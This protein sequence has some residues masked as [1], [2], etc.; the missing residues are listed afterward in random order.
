MQTPIESTAR[1]SAMPDDETLATTIA[2]LA[3]RGF[4]TEV[5]EDLTRRADGA[6]GLGV[7]ASSG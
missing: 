2:A 5:V 6:R 4:G 3:T 1:F 7:R